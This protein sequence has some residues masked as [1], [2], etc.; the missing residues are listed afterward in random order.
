MGVQFSNLDHPASLTDKLTFAHIIMMFIIDSIIYLLAALYIS[1][2]FP[3]RY[4]LPKKWNYFLTKSYWFGKP[5][6]SKNSLPNHLQL[7]T[8]YENNDYNH[9][10][11]YVAGMKLQ[12]L[13]KTYQKNKIKALS[14]FNLTMSENEIT[15]LLGHNGAG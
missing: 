5:K 4:G 2:V 1:N 13:T 7:E 9:K 6:P 12:N 10:N 8:I 3:G 11:Y 14:N 15:V